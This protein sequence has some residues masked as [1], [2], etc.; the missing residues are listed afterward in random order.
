MDQAM[1]VS[2]NG[3]SDQT[4]VFGAGVT[5]RVLVLTP[6]RMQ[7]LGE[8]PSPLVSQC[9]KFHEADLPSYCP[10]NMKFLP[11]APSALSTS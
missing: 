2:N 4:L 10:T 1:V 8:A 3:S 7:S 6:S 5:L 9:A 11:S